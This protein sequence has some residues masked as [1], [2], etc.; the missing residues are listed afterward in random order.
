MAPLDHRNFL[1]AVYQRKA[2][3]LVLNN[4]P[5]DAES[6][7]DS[8]LVRVYSGIVM[9][10]RNSVVGLQHDKLH[11]DIVCNQG[12]PFTLCLLL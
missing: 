2:E 5:K 9:L 3:A 10:H 11:L 1:L 7:R 8:K 12:V 4:K 6:L